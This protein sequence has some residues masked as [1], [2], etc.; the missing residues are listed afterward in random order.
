MNAVVIVVCAV[1][2][3]ALGR[4]TAEAQLTTAASGPIVYGHHHLNVTDVDAQKR[5]WTTL[6]GTPIKVGTSPA[7]IVK[8]ANVFVF[9]TKRDPTGGT[10]GTTVNHLGFQV[11]DVQKAMDAA[12][13]AGYAI[14][15]RAEAPPT[16]EVKGDLA[17]VADQHTRIGYVMGPDE[18]KVELFENTAMTG[19]VALHHVHFASS[20]VGEMQAWYVKTFGAKAG[21]RGSFDAADLPGVN[22]TFSPTTDTVVGTKGRALDHI[23]F[24]VRGLEAFCKQL[25]ANGVTLDRP[26]TKVPAL[27]VSIAFFTDPWGTYIEL[28]E[29]LAA[30][31]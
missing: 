8:F 7:E 22:L 21:K 2:S 28:T 27:G 29:G 9:L 18:I 30:I 14:V 23:G 26:Y 25:E 16:I 17:I 13:A 10:K 12:R 1:L 6:G 15:T 31:P 20:S 11:P 4:A 24:E 5:F 19:P 3:V